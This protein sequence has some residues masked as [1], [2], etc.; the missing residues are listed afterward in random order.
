MATQRCGKD[1]LIKIY[2]EGTEDGP[3]AILKRNSWALSHQVD[4][5]D[6]TA[7]GDLSFKSVSGPKTIELTISGPEMTWYE[8]EPRIDGTELIPI[9]NPK[10]QTPD[11]QIFEYAAVYLPE[12]DQGDLVKKDA[13]ILIEPKT[14]LAEDETQVRKQA[15]REVTLNDGDDLDFVQVAVRPFAH[16]YN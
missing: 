16:Q 4:S 10:E 3:V 15:L 8:T 6:V 1:A 7:F 5:F 12:D 2:S 9:N 14:R 13:R 11:M